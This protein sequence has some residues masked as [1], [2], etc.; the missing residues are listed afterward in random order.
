MQCKPLY[1]FVLN[2]FI[3]YEISPYHL[4]LQVLAYLHKHKRSPIVSSDMHFLD[5]VFV[6]HLEVIQRYILDMILSFM[7]AHIRL[8]LFF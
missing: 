8:Q 6:A 3:K 7:K 1:A 5:G 2:I 4:S